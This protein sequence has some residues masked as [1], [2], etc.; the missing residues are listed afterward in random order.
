MP[1]PSA[2]LQQLAT[3]QPYWYGVTVSFADSAA[4]GTADQV[5][6]RITDTDFI[7][8]RIILTSRID[9][10]G[11]LVVADDVDASGGDGGA[12][13]PAVTIAIQETGTDRSLMNTQID[14]LVFGLLGNRALPVPKLFRASSTVTFNVTLLRDVAAGTGLDLRISLEG[15]NQY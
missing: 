1:I 15:W 7:C 2:L 14:G 10:T 6:I 5:S 13:D 8:T 4:V 11:I 12:P 3:Q 9:D